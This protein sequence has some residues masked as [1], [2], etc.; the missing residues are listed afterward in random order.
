[1]NPPATLRYALAAAARGWH[2]FPVTIGDKVPLTG[3]RWKQHATTDP[4]VIGR[5]WARQPLNIG[6]SCGPSRLVV[7]DLDLP[8]PDEQIPERWR[9]PG[10]N[11]GAD[12]FALLCEEAGQPVPLETFQVRT[13]RGG[14]HLYFTAPD[15]IPLTNTSG[16]Q[17]NGLGWRIDT[18]A[19]I[20]YVVGPGSFVDLPDG[21]G[22]YEPIHTVDPAPLPGWLAERLRPESL[23]PQQPIV[24]TLSPGR[25]GS[26]LDTATRASLEAIAA[27]PEGSLNLTLWGAAVSLGQL[28]AGGAL[29]ATATEDLLTEAA[30]RAGH[31]ETAARRT[32]RSGFRKGANRPRSVPA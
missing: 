21:A 31:P 19:G 13:R 26:Y 6:I 30:V 18:R 11:D 16:D 2:I 3:F 5:I 20:G 8:K 4:E 7:V 9:R 15:D 23:P 24:L 29:N 1:M 25:R 10:V 14:L 32:I 27:A 28:V 22:T 17:G 12:V